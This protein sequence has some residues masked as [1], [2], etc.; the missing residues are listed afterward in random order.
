MIFLRIDKLIYFADQLGL[1]K[2]WL[3]VETYG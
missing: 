2:Y 3:F 1:K